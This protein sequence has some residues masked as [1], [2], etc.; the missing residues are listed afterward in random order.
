MLNENFW[1]REKNVMSENML[2]NSS[3]SS[4]RHSSAVLQ[5]LTCICRILPFPSSSFPLAA[6][7]DH[8]QKAIERR[9]S[10]GEMN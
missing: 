1:S 3:N 10:S 8:L 7:S 2:R 6:R 9:T 4:K 5:K